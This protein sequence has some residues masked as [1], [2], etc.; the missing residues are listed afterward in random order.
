M[1]ACVCESPWQHD[2]VEHR[3]P[4]WRWSCYCSHLDNWGF[5]QYSGRRQQPPYHTLHAQNSTVIYVVIVY[6][7]TQIL[8]EPIIW[9]LIHCWK[10][11]LRK[12]G[13]R[14]RNWEREIERKEKR[15]RERA[16]HL[17]TGGR[18]PITARWWMT[19]PLPVLLTSEE[20]ESVALWELFKRT[21]PSGTC[22]Q[23]IPGGKY[24]SPERRTGTMGGKDNKRCRGEQHVILITVQ[25]CIFKQ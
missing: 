22:P 11:V 9:E 14:K 17:K 2:P 8:H 7:N 20:K 25:K 10:T 23:Y 24:S 6:G 4:R 18:C 19:N 1:C 5:A 16:L 13:M 21:G 15:E 3:W 12:K